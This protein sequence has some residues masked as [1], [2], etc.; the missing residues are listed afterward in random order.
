MFDFSHYRRFALASLSAV[1][2]AALVHLP[3]AA[4]PTKPV[5]I[6]VPFAAG[7]A[8]DIIGRFMA[9]RLGREL[10]Q[11]FVV[12]N[13][14]GANGAIGAESVARSPADGYTLLVVTAGTHAINKSLYRSLPYDPV[15][16]FTHVAMVATAPNVVVVNP[17]V[18]ANNIQELIAF[19]KKSPGSVS[20]GSA[21]S[22]STLHLSGELFKTMTGVDIVHVPYKGGSAATIDLLGGRIQLMF[23][24]IAPAIPNIQAGK[25][26]ALAVTGAK[27]SPMLPD[28]PTVA[29]AGVAGYA[30]TAWFGL[31]GPAGMPPEVTKK[32]NDA[33]NRI[34]A[35]DD[36]REALRKHGAEPFAGTP[37]DFTRHVTTEVAKWAKVVE[38]SGARAD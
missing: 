21:G 8:T 15:K 4:Y 30:A 22:G 17:S 11:S 6:V 33:V 34:L 20:Y 7:G 5:R 32:L 31:V 29:E 3:A 16:D 38:A 1:F 18:P 26:R 12:E 19:M 23:D 36:A 24:S 9:D 35:T 27:R 2:L 10:N 25:I 28:V 14:A 13:R 37:E